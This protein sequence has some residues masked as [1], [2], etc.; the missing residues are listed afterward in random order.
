MD[1]KD[2]R[3]TYRTNNSNVVKLTITH[4]PTGQTVSSTGASRHFLK[5]MLLPM[6][7]RKVDQ[8]NRKNE[9]V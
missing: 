6:L 2:F 9:S 8:E 5:E 1:K 3:F 7:E 4:E